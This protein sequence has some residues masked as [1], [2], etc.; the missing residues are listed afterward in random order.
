[1]ARNVLGLGMSVGIQS[2]APAAQGGIATQFDVSLLQGDADLM[3]RQIAEQR[4]AQEA[5][6]TTP[7]EP[8]APY[9]DADVGGVSVGGSNKS[10]EPA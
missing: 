7:D 1:M 9:S 5:I 8:G 10:P 6:Q 2:L 4:A 3:Q